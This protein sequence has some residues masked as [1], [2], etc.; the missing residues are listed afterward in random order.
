MRVSILNGPIVAGLSA[1][2]RQAPPA[3]YIARVN[4]VAAAL[5]DFSLVLTGVVAAQEA[6]LRQ[7]TPA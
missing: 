6:T 2:C 4:V 5:S 7:A 1:G 3:P